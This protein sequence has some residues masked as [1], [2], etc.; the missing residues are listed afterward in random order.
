MHLRDVVDQFLDQH[1]L[2]YAGAAEQADLSALRIRR[3]KVDDLDSGDQYLGFGGL[4]GVFGGR[5]VDRPL[6]LGDD[7][8]LLVD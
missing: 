6:L 7:R 3:K 2:A 4:L 8:P 1:S 5:A